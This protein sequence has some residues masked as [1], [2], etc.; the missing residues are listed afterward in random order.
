MTTHYADLKNYNED[1]GYYPGKMIRTDSI[2]TEQENYSDAPSFPLLIDCPMEGYFYDP[3]VDTPMSGYLT[4]IVLEDLFV[5]TL[6]VRHG[7]KITGATL[8]TVDSAGEPGKIVTHLYVSSS[9][10]HNKKTG[11]LSKG[12]IRFSDIDMSKTSFLN[13]IRGESLMAT[14]TTKDYPDGEIAGLLHPVFM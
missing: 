5:F 8:Q 2:F 14:I 1:Y 12:T 4:V 10:D 13:A 6:R 7:R 9:Q 11:M 3:A